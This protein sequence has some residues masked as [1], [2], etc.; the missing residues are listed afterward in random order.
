MTHAEA[1]MVLDRKP[2]PQG[3][4]QEFL[5]D[6]EVEYGGSTMRALMHT[7]GLYGRGVRWALGV[8]GR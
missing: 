4:W 5:L 1:L 6:I 8:E 7:P 2:D 3:A